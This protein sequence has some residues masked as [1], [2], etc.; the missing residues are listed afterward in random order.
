MDS[1]VNYHVDLRTFSVLTNEMGETQACKKNP[2]FG[3]AYW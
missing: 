1:P 3:C 2:A